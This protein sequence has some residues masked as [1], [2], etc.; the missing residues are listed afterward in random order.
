VKAVSITLSALSAVAVIWSLYLLPSGTSGS[1]VALCV[2]V[3]AALAA[4]VLALRGRRDQQ[5]R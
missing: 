1:V 3:V 2:G 4:Y 5:G